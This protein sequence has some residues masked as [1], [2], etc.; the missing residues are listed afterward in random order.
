MAEIVVSIFS[1]TPGM[2]VILE[3]EA[4]SLLNLRAILFVWWRSGRVLGIR[5]KSK[6]VG[7]K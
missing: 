4:T 1:S 6:I 3:L 5:F 2:L 7:V